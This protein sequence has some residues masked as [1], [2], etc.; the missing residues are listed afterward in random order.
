MKRL[1]AVVLF[2][3]SGPAKPP[4]AP[5]GP[6]PAA[7]TIC[8]AGVT[9]GMG[10]RSR[11]VARRTVDPGAGT[12]VE[13]VSHDD[14]GA[15]GA[16]SFHVVMQVQGD[17]FTL[18][19]AGGAFTGTGT[20]VGEPW[21]WTSWTSTSQIAKAGIEVDSD[22][23]L[24]AKGMKATKEI[25][26]DGKVL[27]TTSEELATFDC[28][29][30][31]KAVA[32]LAVPALDAAGCE[33]AC[34]NYATLKY[35]A[36]TEAVIA[37]RPEAEREAARKEKL[38]ELATKLDAG[39]ASCTSQCLAADNAVQTACIAAAKTSDALGTCDRE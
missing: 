32:L 25:K 20:L 27:A 33:R 4:V 11:T 39:L 15:H 7:S 18:T 31:D 21:R 5:A 38:A 36:V 10:Q 17:R 29:G 34:R 23:E 24:T 1:V 8:Y 37:A 22:D 6:L 13:D 12:I 9:V 35:W 26:K 19:E 28:A 14:A 16:K 3:C 30:W 2:A